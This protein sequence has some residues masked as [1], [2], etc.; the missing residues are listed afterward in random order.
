MSHSVEINQ[1]L[2]QMRQMQKIASIHTPEAN[3]LTVKESTSEFSN[4]FKSAIDQVNNLQQESGALSKA[5]IKGDGDVDITRV[6][7]ASQKSGLAFQSMVQVRN[8]LVEAYKE[9][10]NMPV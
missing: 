5:Y 1:V 9:I 3:P 10:M 4:V 8:K 7:V 6:M 2:A